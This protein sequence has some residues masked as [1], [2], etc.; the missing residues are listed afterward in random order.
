M[1]NYSRTDPVFRW[2]QRK[3]GENILNLNLKTKF[4]KCY[5]WS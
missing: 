4:L 5:Y 1:V 3:V 2:Q